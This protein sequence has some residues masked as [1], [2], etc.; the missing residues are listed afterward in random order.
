ML[1]MIS[2][3]FYSTYLIRVRIPII[4]AADLESMYL[5]YVTSSMLLTRCYLTQYYWLSVLLT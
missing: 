1:V 2:D 4:P 3:N 5:F